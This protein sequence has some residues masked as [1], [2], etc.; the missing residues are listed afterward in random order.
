MLMTRRCS[1]GS[2]TSAAQRSSTS[3]SRRCSPASASTRY[4]PP[5]T[6]TAAV[7]IDC[8]YPH[9]G[10]CL[11]AITA[12][13][14]TTTTFRPTISYTVPNGWVNGEDLPG[15]FL[16]QLADDPRYLGIYRNVAAPLEC[17]EHPD[18]NVNQSVEAIADWLTSHPGLVTTEPQ[19]V[20]VGGVDG[21]FIDISLDPSW[22]VTCPYSQG[23]PIVPFIIGGGPS[24][25]HHVI[26]P[27]FQ[28]RLYLLEVDGGNLAI[29]VGPEGA[30]L[31]EYLELV[32]PIIESPELRTT[33]RRY[34]RVI[35][36]FW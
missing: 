11:G 18:P 25:L 35:S 34:D 3:R 14:Y 20:A 22:T 16:L 6:S 1:S 17:E 21:V 23:A 29:E 5:T 12:G 26:V 19:A 32:T 31:P 15:N 10:N 8:P 28:E 33:Q 30:S 2:A 13:A 24:S 4:E 7:P 36:Q 27:G 9:G